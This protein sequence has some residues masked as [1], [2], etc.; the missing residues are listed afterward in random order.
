MKRI[1]TLVLALTMTIT[2]VSSAT[3]KAQAPKKVKAK[4][5]ISYLFPKGVPSSE[6]EMKK[7]MKT[8][9]VNIQVR[10][11]KKNGKVKLKKDTMNITV[12][13]KLANNYKKAFDEMYNE[14]FPIKK[15]E[16]VAYVWRKSKGNNQL[17][18][19]SSGAAIDINWN[20]NPVTYNG[21]ISQSNSS[22]KITKKIVKIW[23]KYGFNWGGDWKGNYK[24]PMHF[25]YISTAALN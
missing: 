3:V 20:D 1:M 7:Y 8:I 13:K 15:N 24:D 25:E 19:H 5:R 17:S 11:V 23:K 10:T 18:V 22:Y 6:K 14:K 9:K 21:K 16:T 4:K 12:H 2:A